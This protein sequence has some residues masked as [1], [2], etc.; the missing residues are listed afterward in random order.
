[1]SDKIIKAKGPCRHEKYGYCTNHF[2][3]VMKQ[4]GKPG[5][6]DYSCIIWRARMD[7]LDK[8]NEAVWRAKQFGLTE[9]LREKT[10][11]RAVSRSQCDQPECPDYRL[12]GEDHVIHC[13]YYYYET[14][15]LKFPLCPGD[16]PDFLPMGDQRG[17]CID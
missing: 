11:A 7:A 15:L 1:M 17:G 10:L 3:T 5:L 6:L 9:E 8:Y 16:C 12:S 4:S 2:W 13:R 14:C